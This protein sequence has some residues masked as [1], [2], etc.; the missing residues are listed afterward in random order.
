MVWLFIRG[1]AGMLPDQLSEHDPRSAAEQLAGNTPDG[2]HPEVLSD[3]CQLVGTGF[4][5]QLLYPGDPP[6]RLRAYAKMRDEEILL[7]EYDM[8]AI[9][10]PDGSFAVSRCT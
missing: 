2:W 8:V 5:R 6:F 10:Q 1:D 3:R 7:F 4:K 9:V